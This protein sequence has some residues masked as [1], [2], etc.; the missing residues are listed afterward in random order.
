MGMR[1]DLVCWE[2]CGGFATAHKFS[3]RWMMKVV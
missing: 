3:E 1:G 2:A